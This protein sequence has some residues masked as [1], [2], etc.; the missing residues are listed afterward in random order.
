MTA[1]Q[2]KDHKLSKSTLIF[3]C[4]TNYKLERNTLNFTITWYNQIVVK[5]FSWSLYNWRAV[6]RWNDCRKRCWTH[7]TPKHD[8]LECFE[9]RS[10]LILSWDNL[11]FSFILHWRQNRIRSESWSNERTPWRHFANY[12]VH[13]LAIVY[14]LRGGRSH[15]HCN[16]Y[17]VNVLCHAKSLLFYW[18]KLL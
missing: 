9:Q 17:Q 14:N 16:S 2:D 13:T 7:K 3:Y 18:I 15:Q 11:V 12:T 1:T 8:F 4:F 6:E 10:G 5:E